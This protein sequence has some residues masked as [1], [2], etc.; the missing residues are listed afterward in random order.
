[1]KR[2]IYIFF[3]VQLILISSCT[4]TENERVY[5]NKISMLEQALDSVSE[6]YHTIDTVRLIQAYQS[7][8]ADLSRLRKI[9]TI[10]ND[11]VKI[12]AGLQKSF[13]R[14]IGEHSLIIKEVDYSKN[15]LQ[16]LKSDIGKGKISDEKIEKYYNQEMEAVGSL[17]SKMG[18]NEKSIKYQLQLFDVLHTHIQLIINRFE[19]K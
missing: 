16:A 9:D 19:N 10:L 15:Q 11:S 13:K 12:Y 5:I 7:I 18:Y 14:F 2:V 4:I 1:M 6:Q 17:I 3:L 8:N